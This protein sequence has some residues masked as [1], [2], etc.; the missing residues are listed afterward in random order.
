MT[1]PHAAARP[2]ARAHVRATRGASGDVAISWIR[3]ARIDG[4]SWGPGDVPLGENAETCQLDILSGTVVKRSVAV[5]GSA[6]AYS[7]ANQ[8]VDFG[9]RPASL[10]LRVAQLDS[11]G[12]PGLNTELTITL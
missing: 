1:L 11:S 8:I 4:D 12:A 5:T 6:Y 10:H 7:S 9:A 3:C 2:W